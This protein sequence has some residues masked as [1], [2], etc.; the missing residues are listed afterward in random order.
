VNGGARDRIVTPDRFECENSLS[1]KAQIEYGVAASN[2]SSSNAFSGTPTTAGTAVTVY[3]KLIIPIGAPK[4]RIDC[5][6]LYELEVEKRM[7]EIKLLQMQTSPDYFKP[8]EVPK[9]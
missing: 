7:L 3:G 1:G 9:Q 2:G 6:R 4:S 5:N 8:A